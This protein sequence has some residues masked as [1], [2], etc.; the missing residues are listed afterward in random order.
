M[1][2]PSV[3]IV[4]L[5][6]NGKKW[7]EQFLPSVLQTSYTNST[8]YVADNASTDGSIAFL[9][10]QFPTV[11]IIINAENGGFAKGYNTALQKITADYYVLLNSDVEVTS[12]WIA[13]IIALMEQDSTIG[14]CQPK[15]LSYAQK[16]TF[17]YAGASGGLI[18]YLGYPFARGRILDTC[19]VDV[20][21]YN[22]TVEVFWASGAALF[23]KANLFHQL[24]GFDEDFF[25]HQ[26]E[27]DFCWRSQL[28]GFKVYVCPASV[29]YHV[30]GGTLQQGN[31]RKT[32]LNF[33]NNMMMLH[34]NL[35]V[36]GRGL[37]LLIRHTLNSVAAIQFLLKGDFKSSWAVIQAK[38]D[39]YK[40]K[41]AKK[42]TANITNQKPLKA[43]AGVASKSIIFQYFIKKKKTYTQFIH[44]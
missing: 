16:D 30:G 32:Y 14:C 43:C 20:G 38:V 22:D 44:L 1:H 17:E 7:L 3:A 12:N 5:N 42:N 39:F 40:W 36:K 9:Q 34:K 24:K 28:A 10:K 6:W 25:A 27:I 4:I 15:I 31:P 13:P 21:Q 8:I 37:L 41:F 33:R 18:D 11:R 35:P 29:V 2:T 19:E 26:E 23:V